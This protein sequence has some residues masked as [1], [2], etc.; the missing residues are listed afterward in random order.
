MSKKLLFV[1]FIYLIATASL[2]F[3]QENKILATAC[4]VYMDPSPLSRTTATGEENVLTGNYQG[5]AQQYNN[6]SGTITGV[7]FFGRVNPASASLTNTLKVIIYNANL[8]LPGTI[9]GSQNVILNSSATAYEVNV[10]FTTPVNVNGNI[11][12]SIEPFSPATDN[13]FIGRNTPPDGQNLNLIKIKQAN[14]WFKNLAAGDPAFDFDFLILPLKTSTVTAAFTAATV[15]NITS[16]TN[17]SIN[18]VSYEWNFGDGNNSTSASPTHSYASSGM[19]NVKLKA[20]AD[21]LSSCADS[22]TTTVN[23]VLTGLN[24]V[25]AITGITI[26]SNTVSEKLEIKSSV[27]SI[28]SIVNSKGDKI[29]EFNVDAFQPS[30]INVERLNSGIY[31]IQT[32]GYKPVK[33][34]KIP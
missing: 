10:S 20:Y 5:V 17:N 30:E 32:A 11:I 14:Q 19:Y 29:M 16:F 21:I 24:E 13:F 8:G 15:N 7:K 27:S 31:F 22:I 2:S 12:I 18:G 9:L 1:L 23:V 28:C 33:F 34:I 3:A 26:L 6:I 4:D 25:S